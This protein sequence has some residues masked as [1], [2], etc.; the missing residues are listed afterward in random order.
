M[1]T[2]VN[3]ETQNNGGIHPG[4]RQDL[5]P[6]A[7]N[8]LLPARLCSWAVVEMAHDTINVTTTGARK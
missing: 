3:A 7:V 5:G 1:V 6:S 4:Q 2:P 8:G